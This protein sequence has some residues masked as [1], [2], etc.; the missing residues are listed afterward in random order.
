MSQ[1]PFQKFATQKKNSAVKEAFRQHKKK[2]KKKEL[3]ILIK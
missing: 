3:L 2:A 1:S